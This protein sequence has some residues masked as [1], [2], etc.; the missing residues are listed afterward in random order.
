MTPDELIQLMRTCSLAKVRAELEYLN[1]P[2][3]GK[4]RV[5]DFMR[6]GF[7]R[8]LKELEEFYTGAAQRK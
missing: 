4:G 5:Q 6:Q 3:K 8:R 1:N 7:V 2:P